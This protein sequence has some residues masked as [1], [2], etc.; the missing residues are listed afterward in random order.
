MSLPHL[1][2]APEPLRFIDLFAGIGGFHLAFSQARG[3]CVFSSEWNKFSQQTYTVNFGECPYGDIATIDANDV[4][5]HDILVAGFP[6][7]P[8]SRAGVSTNNSLGRK[9]GFDHPTQGTAFFDIV[10]IL[11]Q[12]RPRAFLLENV[13]NLQSHDRGRTFRT[14]LDAL[15]HE[16]GYTVYHQVLSAHPFVPQKRKRIFIVGFRTPALYAFPDMPNSAPSLMEILEPTADDRYTLSD[17]TWQWHLR[18][19]AKHKA[20]GHGFGYGMAD[21]DGATRTLSARYHKDGAEILVPQGDRNPRRLTPRECARLMGFPD[22]FA[23]P[24]SDTQAYKQFGNAVVVPLARI[25][26]QSVI[27]ALYPTVSHCIP[28]AAEDRAANTILINAPSGM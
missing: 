21:L 23:I 8:F 22:D 3:Q 15:E 16:L 5:D 7:Q 28:D 26:A 20:K 27:D 4:P 19:A 24:V 17:N 11:A 9:H 25:V 2:K 14:I 1:P 18:H 12:K 6:C 13:P 10:R